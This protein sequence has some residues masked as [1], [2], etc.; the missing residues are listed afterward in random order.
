MLV[1]EQGDILYVSGKTGKY[2]ESAVGRANVNLFAMAR[3]GLSQ[4]LSEIF[5]KAIRE[6]TTLTLKNIKVG[7]NGGTQLVNVTVQPLSEQTVLHRMLMVIFIDVPVPRIKKTSG[8]GGQPGAADDRMAALASELQHAHEALQT[9]R[10]EMQTSQEE[11]KS[12]NEELQSTNEELQSTNEE[13]T[14]SKEV[15]QSMNEEL[16]TVNSEL[17]AK[18]EELSRTSDDMR[19]LL[20]SVN[21]AI[22]FLDEA[23]NVRRFTSQTASIIKLIPSDIGRPITDLMTELEYPQL[24]DDI[25]EVLDTLIFKETEAPTKDGRWFMVRI[26]PYRTQENRIDGAVITFTNISPAKQLE[27][28]LR[29]TQ[30]EL[31]ERLTTQAS[32]L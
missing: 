11:L 29:K 23:L 18:L 26:L 5:N 31:Q 16:Q 2:S 32:E 30:A 20:N 21:I 27:A 25:R 22:L 17:R 4:A 28:E 9:A 7:T 1:T 13:L 3:P 15:M 12:T 6:Q 19:N 10:E 8:K 14:T 24:I